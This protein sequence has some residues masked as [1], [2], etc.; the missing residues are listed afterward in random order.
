MS[1]QTN[2]PPHPAAD[3][4]TEAVSLSDDDIFHILQTNRRR[5]AIRYLLEHDEPVK[6]RDVAEYVAAIENDTT[7]AELS[8]TERQRVYIP[9]YQSHL[10]KLDSEGIIEYNK[11]RGVVR[12]TET[13]EL[14]RPYLE[15]PGTDAERKPAD[16]LERRDAVLAVTSASLLL[17]SAIGTYAAVTAAAT[18]LLLATVLGAVAIPGFVLGTIATARFALTLGDSD[19]PSLSRAE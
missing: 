8:S 1:L 10:P 12:P 2:H 17:A 7:V 18:S 4:E 11:S 14:F 16:T 15:L 9:L 13:L 3:A 5:D 6:M 19:A